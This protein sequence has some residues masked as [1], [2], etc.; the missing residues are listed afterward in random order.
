LFWRSDIGILVDSLAFLF[1]G[2]ALPAVGIL[3]SQPSP[4]FLVIEFF[5]GRKRVAEPAQLP[6]RELTI[7]PQLRSS[8]IAGFELPEKT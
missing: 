1:A 3:S 6:A 7:S 4:V 5:Y 2:S 8:I